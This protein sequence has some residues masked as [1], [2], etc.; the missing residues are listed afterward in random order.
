MLRLVARLNMGGP[1]L[2]V[3]Y[4]TKGLEQYGY[5]TTLAAGTVGHGERSMS[6]VADE[7][8]VEVFPI[9]QLH[10]D[11]SP[12]YDTESVTSIVRLIR[13]LR[14][15]ILHTH[16]AKAGAIGRVASAAAADRV[17]PGAARTNSAGALRSAVLLR[18]V[19]CWW[20]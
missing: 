14:P 2:H 13:R 8:G 18:S 17:W 20:T 7:L 11:I 6:F 4:L 15:H 10:R 12:F 1:A 3:S 16:T 19:Q 9:P 5:E